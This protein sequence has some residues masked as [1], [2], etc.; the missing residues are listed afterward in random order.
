MKLNKKSLLIEK[1]KDNESGINKTSDKWFI[2]TGLLVLFSLHILLY[3]LGPNF[4]DLQSRKYTTGLAFNNAKKFVYF[5]YNDHLFPLTL[6]ELPDEMECSETNSSQL[7]EERG[8][9]L[10]ME[11][12]HWSRMGE[13][14]RIFVFLPDAL[15]EGPCKPSVKLFNSLC[16][17]IAILALFYSLTKAGYPVLALIMSLAFSLTP[18]YMYEVYRN[19]NI[20]TLL[21][22]VFIFGTSLN[23]K[24]LLKND[25]N[26]W[27]FLI[28]VASGLIISFFNE[29]RGEI[30]VVLFSV[31]ALYLLSQK[32]SWI[33]RVLYMLLL[34]SSFVGTK[35]VLRHYFDRKFEQTAEVVKKAGGHVYT[36]D[37]SGSHTFWHP[38]FC[39]LGDFD[40]KYGYKWEDR[41]AYTYA[42]PVLQSKYHINL[43][44][45]G[46]YHFDAWYDKDSLY[47]IK[48]EEFPEYEEIMKDKVLSDIKQDPLW[49]LSI[50]AKRAERILN[51]T[52][53]FP[54][55]GWFVFP[56][57]GILWWKR[58][59]FLIKL[60]LIS[61]PL[62]L[63]PLMIYSG[64]NS[65]FNSV[66]PLITVSI[67]L[68]MVFERLRVGDWQ[69]LDT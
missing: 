17:L 29:I 55:A 52:L 19:K 54:W 26:K 28:P 11:Y 22:V 20:F 50:L 45:S 18:F 36:G 61:L 8:N 47:Y 38:V 42:I 62:S 2:R 32:L 14:A 33:V 39:G 9:D 3:N 12:K 46:K 68:W 57:T 1:K 56:L 43:P 40:T 66:F 16:F 35:Q 37:R 24:F 60:I 53:P 67:I 64:G 63:T 44:Y 34:L 25:R 27:D 4:T 31:L 49:F 58:N 30:K 41:V 7:I 15:I 6:K 5:Y 21:A 10:I 48:F 65:T 69:H 59:W 13:H 51:K 23:L